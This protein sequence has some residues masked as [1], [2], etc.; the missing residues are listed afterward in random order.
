M[1]NRRALEQEFRGPENLVTVLRTAILILAV[2]ETAIAVA[3]QYVPF[4]YYDTRNT[5]TQA[6]ALVEMAHLGV[7]TQLLLRQGHNCAYWADLDYTLRAFPNHPRALM[8]MANFLKM[9]RK[10]K[11][12]FH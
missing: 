10:Y 1:T 11:P 8:M 5:P 3:E 9:Y 2:F 12:H 6:Y 4:D 7:R